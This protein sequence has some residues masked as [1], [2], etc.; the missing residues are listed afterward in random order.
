MRRRRWLGCVL[1]VFLGTPIWAGPVK[2]LRV[3]STPAPV[4]DKGTTLAN[5]LLSAYSDYSIQLSSSIDDLKNKPDD[6]EILAFTLHRQSEEGYGLYVVPGYAAVFFEKISFSPMLDQFTRIDHEFINALSTTLRETDKIPDG[7]LNTDR[8]PGKEFTQFGIEL[9]RNTELQNEVLLAAMLLHE[10]GHLFHQHGVKKDGGKDESPRKEQERQADRFATELIARAMND[11]T[12]PQ[13]IKSS[14]YL[15]FH[16][17]TML[18]FRYAGNRMQKNQPTIITDPSNQ[19]EDWELRIFRMLQHIAEELAPNSKFAGQVAEQLDQLLLE[20]NEITP[21]QMQAKAILR[22]LYGLISMERQAEEI[23]QRLAD[24]NLLPLDPERPIL[25]LQQA[26]HLYSASDYRGAR[27]R[28]EHALTITTKLRQRRK[29]RGVQ[30]LGP[31][32]VI[33]DLL[34]NQGAARGYCYEVEPLLVASAEAP[35][36]FKTHVQSVCRRISAQ[37]TKGLEAPDQGIVGVWLTINAS[38]EEDRRHGGIYFR[39]DGSGGIFAGEYKRE[40]NVEKPDDLQSFENLLEAANFPQEGT[41]DITF[42]YSMHGEIVTIH[43]K[44][45]KGIEIS[46]DP[47][48]SIYYLDSNMLRLTMARERSRW[49]LFQRAE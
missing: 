48:D 32:A 49:V 20:R 1:L 16:H 37:E 9:M 26:Q 39:T 34:D 4:L 8:L 47:E 46:A 31:L 23:S 6:T 21:D 29:V 38:D 44:T 22:S 17:L 28:L 5:K 35:E 7:F 3:L 15:M 33:E 40:N 45:A 10:I 42:K 12:A 36:A 11:E 2:D 27:N 24:P 25:L 30:I 43:P 41:V 14:A 13:D 19:Y 18:G